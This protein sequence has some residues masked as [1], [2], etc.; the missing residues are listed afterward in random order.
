MTMANDIYIY[1][2]IWYG[3]AK[4]DR[5]DKAVPASGSPILYLI[6]Q[7]IGCWR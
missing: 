6:R 5:Q 3:T 1:T 2:D 7:V 4:G